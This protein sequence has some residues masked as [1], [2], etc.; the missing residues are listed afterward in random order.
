M[1]GGVFRIIH[2][3]Y[4][5]RVTLPSS[6][7]LSLSETPIKTAVQVSIYT[8]QTSRGQ[9]LIGELQSAFNDSGKYIHS[10]SILLQ[11]LIY[12]CYVVMLAEIWSVEFKQL[13]PTSKTQEAHTP[14]ALEKLLLEENVQSVGDFMFIEWPKLQEELLLTTERSAL[15]RADTSEYISLPDY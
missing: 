7:I 3:C 4:I 11:K 8:Q 2:N 13:S 14:A 5:R 12:Q 10:T 6:D 9:L 15:R 1:S